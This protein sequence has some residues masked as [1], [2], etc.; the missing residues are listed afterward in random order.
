MK[1]AGPG[2]FLFSDSPA[3]EAPGAAIMARLFSRASGGA[4]TKMSQLL[5]FA[6]N[7]PYL[8]GGVVV[9]SILVLGNELRLRSNADRKSTRLNSSH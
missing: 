4:L 1:Y 2:L 9:L 5:E 6:A 7:H 8:V 3:T